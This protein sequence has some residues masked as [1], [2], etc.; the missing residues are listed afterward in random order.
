MESVPVVTIS[1][2][3]NAVKKLEECIFHN[4]NITTVVVVVLSQTLLTAE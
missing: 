1:N 4:N 2:I 3:A